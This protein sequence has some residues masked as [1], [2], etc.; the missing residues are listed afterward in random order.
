MSR[1]MGYFKEDA[2]KQ[3][4]NK[5]I[6]NSVRGF[7]HFILIYYILRYLEY[8]NLEAKPMFLWRIF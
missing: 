4:H 2:N 1:I 5:V 6:L 3:Y 8:F 7:L